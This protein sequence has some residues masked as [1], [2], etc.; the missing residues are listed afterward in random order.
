MAL[1]ELLRGL[2]RGLAK[3]AQPLLRGL[4]LAQQ[5]LYLADAFK[6]IHRVQVA[7]MAGLGLHP[8][9]FQRLWVWTCW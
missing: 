7:A 2:P 8:G 1:L 6:P 5:A 4:S 9:V 3:L